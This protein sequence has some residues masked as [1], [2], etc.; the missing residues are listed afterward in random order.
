MRRHRSG[1]MGMAATM[2]G[3]GVMGPPRPPGSL[4]VLGPVPP[5][6]MPIPPMGPGPLMGATTNTTNSKDPIAMDSRLFVGNLNTIALSKQAVEGIFQRY[7]MLLGVSMHKGYAFVQYNHPDEARRAGA[8]EDGKVYAG[9]AIDINIVSQPKARNTLKRSAGGKAGND[10]DS[11]KAKKELS[12]LMKT[13]IGS[14]TFLTLASTG[15]SK[16]AVSSAVKKAIAN[17]NKKK[18]A[19][20]AAKG[21]EEEYEWA[22]VLI[23]GTCKMQFTSLQVLVDHKENPCKLR[24]SS[25]IMNEAGDADNNEPSCLLCANCDAEFS[26]GWALCKHYEE[27]HKMKIYKIK[28]EQSENGTDTDDD[29][30]DDEKEM[31]ET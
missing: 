17:I 12:P 8:C 15:N 6:G 7:G 19:A 25:Q 11:K 2:G 5:M 18:A 1:P 22:D 26:S 20:A 3:M 24:V 9:Q 4:G 13:G 16:R 10:A 21:E 28:E 30:D 14:R 31:A 27:E 29:D 23:C